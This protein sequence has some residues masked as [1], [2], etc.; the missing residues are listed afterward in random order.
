MRKIVQSVL[1][2]HPFHTLSYTIPPDDSSTE[3]EFVNVFK[4]LTNRFQRIDSASLCSLAGRYVK[5]GYEFRLTGLY[6]IKL[7]STQFED[8]KVSENLG[9][10]NYFFCYLQ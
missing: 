5:Y 9:W 3:P 1:L 6:Y 7:Q 10:K 2:R 4:E 8:N